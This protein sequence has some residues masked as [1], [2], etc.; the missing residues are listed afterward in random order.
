MARC[1]V[2]Q[3]FGRK[4][5]Y[6]DGRELDLDASYA[7]IKEAVEAAG[8]ECLRADEI[9]HSGTIDQ[10][11]YEHL[12]RSDL[13]IADLSTQ[14]INAAFELGVRY[15]LR[16]HA[17][18]IVAEE[19]FKH[20][21]DVSHIM[22]RRYKHLGEDIGRKEAARFKQELQEAMAEIV[23]GGKVDSPVYT[24]LSQLLPP[25]E[26]AAAEK[27]ADLAAAAPSAP[28]DG[29]T[30]SQSSSE[31]RTAKVLL[32]AALAWIAA[33]QPSD[34]VGARLLL[35]CLREQRPNDHFVIHQLA[36]ATYRSEQPT[37]LDALK[38]AR[39]Q[40]SALQP[41]STNN[42][43]TLSLWGAIHKRLWSLEQRPEQLSESIHAYWRSFY[44]KQDSYNGVN[45]ARLLEVRSLQSARAGARD[46]AIADRVLARRVRED[47]LRYIA[48]HLE[49]L[50]ELRPD[51][52]Y[53]ALASL[54]AVNAGLGRAA[55]ATRWEHEARA[56]MSSSP[57]VQT[58]E[59]QIARMRKT[60]AEL[61]AALSASV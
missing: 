4:T 57:M 26:R 48:P 19:G 18:I 32:E 30:A 33:G 1:F 6:T 28:A 8:H 38:E 20:A 44:V 45:L 56:L 39:D 25:Q 42:P 53:W 10:P 23:G 15:G 55:D 54:W 40:L 5:D 12:L 14:N 51:K 22:I 24:F 31:S 49:D 7:V 36:L 52:R 37:P 17:T 13:V 50:D 60:Q 35:E 3:G 29:C 46:E 58:T 47:V 34:F 41:Q 43:E 27:A 11:M 59:Q 9:K 61:D 21:F 2:V 16:P